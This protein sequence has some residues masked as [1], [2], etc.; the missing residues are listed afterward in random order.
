MAEWT[1]AEGGGIVRVA[2]VDAEEFLQG[3]I[4][5]DV[6]KAGPEAAI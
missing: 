1:W 4:S 5:N 2:G 3:L 6:T